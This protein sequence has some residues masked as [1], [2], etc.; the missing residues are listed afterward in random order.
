MDQTLVS[1][2][3]DEI[4]QLEAKAAALRSVV[5]LYDVNASV[6]QTA[7]T[8]ARNTTGSSGKKPSSGTIA[9]VILTVAR[10]LV[11]RAGGSPVPT[12]EILE[13]HCT[14]Q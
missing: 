9:D 14:L 4:A 6:A 2:M 11:E 12:M 8:P 10:K 13:A 1:A 3:K 7:Q 5:A